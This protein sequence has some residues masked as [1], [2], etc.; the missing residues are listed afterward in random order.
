MIFRAHNSSFV[1]IAVCLLAVVVVFGPSSLS[2]RRG[3]KGWHVAEQFVT[4]TLVGFKGTHSTLS[5]EES[6][7]F[8]GAWIQAYQTVY[9]NDDLDHEHQE[10]PVYPAIIDVI[11]KNEK[12]R[13]VNRYDGSD[14]KDSND[15]IEEEDG[16]RVV[17][18]R[19][20]GMN[21]NAKKA[22]RK[23]DKDKN[24]RDDDDNGAKGYKYYDIS[25][26]VRYYCQRCWNDDRR[27][28]LLSKEKTLPSP[29][30][31][32]GS[33]SLGMHREQKL[34]E[35]F[36]ETLLYMLL[37]GPYEVFH[38]IQRCEISFVS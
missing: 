29:T 6:D 7:F 37:K 24:K 16:H 21:R 19:S 23:K 36:K 33:G 14:D 10:H 34:D 4:T 12:V 17:R 20:L 30:T 32:D 35:L 38:D 9:D 11:I 31:A 25:L 5:I 18:R 13:I 1:N 26:T 3:G 8:D 15:E 28:I 22:E 27:R 2:E